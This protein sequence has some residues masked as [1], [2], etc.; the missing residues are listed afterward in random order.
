MESCDLWELQPDEILEIL[1]ALSHS[2]LQTNTASEYVDEV[3]TKLSEAYK[4]RARANKL[5]QKEE[6]EEKM[7]R[8]QE[9]LARKLKKSAS[10]KKPPGRPKGFSPK[11]GITLKDFYGNSK[12]GSLSDKSLFKS[13]RLNAKLKSDGSSDPSLEKEKRKED[14]EKRER[15]MKFCRYEELLLKRDLLLRNRPLGLDRNHDRYWMFHTTTPGLYI[16]KGWSDYSHVY[17][18][19]QEN[20]SIK[21]EVEEEDGS[22]YENM[23][24]KCIK[25]EQNGDKK[26]MVSI[27]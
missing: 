26:S 20:M 16:E 27:F 1:K 2:F 7:R 10:P 15:E 11:K 21:E 24:D 9:R 6:L 17:E 25:T 23:K 14:D 5:Q 13:R 8:K 4:E 18:V 19:K 22:R 3:E 12:K